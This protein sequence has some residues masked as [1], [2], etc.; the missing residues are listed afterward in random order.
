MGLFKLSDYDAEI[1]QSIKKNIKKEYGKKDDDIIADRD[2][3]VY[4]ASLKPGLE[5]KA[6]FLKYAEIPDIVGYR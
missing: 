6:V 1:I 4:L 3:E 2:I 5:Q